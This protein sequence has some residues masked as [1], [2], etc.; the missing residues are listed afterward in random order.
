MRTAA[1]VTS[2]EERGFG[3]EG[4]WGRMREEMLAGKEA[5]EAGEGGEG[6]EGAE[7]KKGGLVVGVLVVLVEAKG[8]LAGVG[9]GGEGGG[10]GGAEG[11]KG[12]WRVRRLRVVAAEVEGR[13]GVKDKI[14]RRRRMRENGEEGIVG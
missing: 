1:T 6:G 5:K 12:W 11:K 3:E 4:E 10:V 13:R 7:G 8:Y 9:G 2:L 14:R